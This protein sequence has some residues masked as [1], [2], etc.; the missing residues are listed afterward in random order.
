MTDGKVSG[1]GPGVA[2]GVPEP[3]AE[4]GGDAAAGQPSGILHSV[5]G[6]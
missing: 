4:R 1:K 3:G 5:K 6:R 2:G